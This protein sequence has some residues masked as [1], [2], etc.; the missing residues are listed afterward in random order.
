MI[1]RDVGNRQRGRQGEYEELLKGVVAL[2]HKLLV[3]IHNPADRLNFS[4][5]TR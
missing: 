3:F 5:V 1:W 2:I 4:F